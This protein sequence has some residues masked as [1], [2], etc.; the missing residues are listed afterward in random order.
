MTLRLTEART[1]IIRELKAF[2]ESEAFNRALAEKFGLP[3]EETHADNGIQ[4]YLDGY[5]ISPHPDVRR[6]ALTY[7]VNIN[8]HRD[9]EARDHHTHY[10][11][12]KDRYAYIEQFWAGNPDVDRCWVPWTWCDSVSEQRANNSIVIFAPGDDTLHAVKAS[13]DHLG[14]QRTQLYGNLWYK[15]RHRGLRQTQWGELDL[16]NPRSAGQAGKPREAQPSLLSKVRSIVPRQLKAGLKA[17]LKTN[18]VPES[19]RSQSAHVMDR[20]GTTRL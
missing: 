16:L 7:M 3:F 18:G 8:P 4:K 17:Q 15:E 1:D 9:A 2:L 6:K 10:M 13:Y 20:P 19:R 5:E 12:F 14:A 11:K